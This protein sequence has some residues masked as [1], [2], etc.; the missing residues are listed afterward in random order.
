MVSDVLCEAGLRIP[1]GGASTHTGVYMALVPDLEF[2][3]DGMITEW[4]YDAKVTESFSAIVFRHETSQ[5]FSIV[6]I[7]V[8]PPAF[9]HI[10]YRVPESER[11][12]VTNG[13]FIGWYTHDGTVLGFSST[14]SSVVYYD[15]SWD[16]SIAP[17]DLVE[18]QTFDSQN[19]MYSIKAMVES[20]L[21]LSGLCGQ[22]LKEYYEIFSSSHLNTLFS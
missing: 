14:A 19:R 2:D 16:K 21:S 3:C 6:G 9:G 15:N 10:V 4:E 22:N 8:I 5:N 13:D 1:Y 12:F 17:G 11:V 20:S 18:T 7:N